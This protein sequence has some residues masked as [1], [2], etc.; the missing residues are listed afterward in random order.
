MAWPQGTA[1]SRRERNKLQLVVISE[2]FSQRA[3]L[4]SCLDVFKD[5]VVVYRNSRNL[6]FGA[7]CWHSLG[8]VP[9]HLPERAASRARRIDIS[10]A[11]N[12]ATPL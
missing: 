12:E 4:A 1:S 11:V 5:F 2:I 7:V 8:G 3:E 10:K 9:L 6:S